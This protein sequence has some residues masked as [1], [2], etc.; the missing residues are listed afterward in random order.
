MGA[1]RVRRRHM[2]RLHEPAGLKR[3][4]RQKREPYRGKS[5]LDF[6]KV[7]S[8]PRVTPKENVARGAFDRVAAPKGSVT[9]EKGP[10]RPMSRGNGRDSNF[11]GCSHKLPPIQLGRFRS[12]LHTV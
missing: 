3:A 11:G 8:I 2:G 7:R 9:V 6:E 12:S 4:N 10:A 5:P 1:D